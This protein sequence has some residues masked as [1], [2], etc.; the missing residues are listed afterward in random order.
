[1]P[2]IITS[3]DEESGGAATGIGLHDMG[4][5]NVTSEKNVCSGGGTNEDPYI[6]DWDA[7]DSENPFNWTKSRKWLITL[8]LAVSTWVAAFCSSSYTGGLTDTMGEF[9]ISEEVA[10]LGVS[11]YVLG[12]ALGPFLWAPLSEMYGRRIVFIG[13]FTV[14]TLLHL[15]G[16]LGRNTTTLLV[17]RTLAGIFGVSPFTNSGGA[18]ADIWVPRERGIASS[19]YASAPFMGPVLGPIVG[20]WVSQSRLGWHFVFWIMFIISALSLLRFIATP[21]TY[22]PVLLRWRARRLRRNSASKLIYISKF[23][24][25]RSKSRWDII[26]RNM[27]RPF[28]FLISEPIVL[29]LAIYMSIAYATLYAFFAAYPIVFEEQRHFSH[30]VGGLA[31]IGVGVGTTFGLCL[32]PIQNRLYWRAMDHS[33]TG[34]APPE[35]RLYSPMAGAFCLPIGLFWFAWTSEPPVPWIV[36]ILAGAPSGMGVALIMQGLTQYFMDAYGIYGASALAAAVV[37]RSISAAIFPEVVPIMYRNL[38]D[39]WACS[40]FAFLAL[41][42]MPLPFLFFK[43][44]PW[45]RSR[46]RW[47]LKDA[48]PSSLGRSTRRHDTS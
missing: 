34:R 44:G 26:K 18:L 24:V 11:L 20:G 7:A 19:L 16:S 2:Q 12:F 37:L 17:T 4:T 46:S 14:F 41:A 22:G 48:L 3:H 32:A 5:P 28:L 40:I 25:G 39:A 9:H 42:C 47:A 33:T 27:E 45:I 30:G 8:Q 15:G 43:Y 13:T 21:E 31:F 6:V 10:L 38:G 23:D 29:L 1:M 36:P 35:A